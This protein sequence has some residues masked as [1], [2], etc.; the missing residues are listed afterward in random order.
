MKEKLPKG[1][2][3]LPCPHGQRPWSIRKILMGFPLNFYARHELTNAT[4][5]PLVGDD[6]ERYDSKRVHE[7]FS[8]SAPNWKR[9][10]ENG[11][12]QGCYH[13]ALLRRKEILLAV[14]KKHLDGARIRVL[15]AGTGPGSVAREFALRNHKVTALD[16]SW[17]MLRQIEIAT[18]EPQ[19]MS[20]VNADVRQ[21]PLRD[22]RFE[23]AL[24]MG[25]IQYLAED[26]P[27]IDELARVITPHGHLM[28]SFPNKTKLHHF[29]DPRSLIR[30][31]W[32]LLMRTERRRT[33]S[34]TGAAAVHSKLYRLKKIQTMMTLHGFR[35]LDIRA[36]DFGPL[37]FFGMQF[38][39][40]AISVGLSNALS[41]IST[42]AP[43]RWLMFFT[44]QWAILFC[45]E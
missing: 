28:M 3:R 17:E 25:V 23:L 16:L 20:A 1:S 13:A 4:A 11:P 40:K 9:V 38:L 18:D 29:L 42:R 8:R 24:C 43:F 39:P 44:N 7:H 36:V 30:A 19:H 33:S 5:T 34:L 21:L 32:V 22:R 10:Y 26:G 41:K 2:G 15:D 27:C 14:L 37:T 6:P 31:V 12:I 45:K 35:T